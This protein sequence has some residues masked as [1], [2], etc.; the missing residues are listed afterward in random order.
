VLKRQRPDRDRLVEVEWDVPTDRLFDVSIIVEV[1]NARGVLAAVA[2]AIANSSSNIHNVFMDEKRADTVTT[3]NFTI[4][5]AHR[6]HL[7]QVMRNVR[8]VSEV[9]RVLRQKAARK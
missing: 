3:L 6:K 9:L 5:V 7:A 4:E 2:T 1:R 8:K